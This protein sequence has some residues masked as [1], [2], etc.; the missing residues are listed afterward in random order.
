ME[1]KSDNDAID[2]RLPNQI[3]NAILTFG[4]SILVL[5]KKHGSKIKASNFNFIPSTVVRYTGT[6]DYFE[7]VSTFDRFISSGI[8]SFNKSTLAKALAGKKTNGKVYNRLAL[9]QRILQK[10]AF[11]QLYY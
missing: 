7:V 11:N 2:Q 9:V 1:V 6:E 5:D 8:F 4:L 10:L 3:I